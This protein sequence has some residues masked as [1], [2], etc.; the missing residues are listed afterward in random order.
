MNLSP[1][2][3]RA[4]QAVRAWLHSGDTREPFR[5]FGS[6]GTGKSTLAKYL[7]DILN[8]VQFCSYTGKAAHVLQQKGCEGAAT[9]HSLIYKVAEKDKS[10]IRELE[11]EI[12][13]EHAQGNLFMVEHLEGVLKKLKKDLKQPTFMLNPQASIRDYDLVI[14]DECSMVDDRMGN[15]LLSFGVPILVLGDRHQLPPIKGQG[16]FTRDAP[17]FELTEIHRQAEDSGIIRFS[18]DIRN[19]CPVF[20]AGHYGGDVQFCSPEEFV[21]EVRPA[22]RLPTQVIVGLN[23]T[24]HKANDTLRGYMGLTSVFPQEGDRVICLKNNADKGILNGAQYDVHF[25]Q[26]SPYDDYLRMD[27]S[28]E[29]GEKRVKCH[30]EVFQRK[31]IPYTYIKE[32][33]QFDVANAIT[34]HKA[35]GSGWDSVVV[36]DESN[37]FRKDQRKWRYSAC[38]RAAKKLIW[39]VA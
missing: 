14:L 23:K 6:A 32:A 13:K 31:E 35:Q 19:G 8:K 7:G 26:S 2:Q 9:I 30:R 39:V 1:E 4:L 24:R 25:C 11:K 37:K 12:E 22:I 15:D 36:V 3:D 10:R 21:N 28:D 16:F 38:T 27:I 34:C 33:D 20:T 5:L 18:T 29:S 17:D